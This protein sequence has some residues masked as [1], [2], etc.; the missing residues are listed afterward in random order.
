M[1]EFTRAFAPGG[2]FFFTVVTHRRRPLFHAQ[3]ARALLRTV[4]EDV[5]SR[6]PFDLD[7]IVLLPDHLHCIWTLPPEDADFSTRWRKIKEVFTRAWLDTGAQESRVSAGQRRKG[8]RGVWQ[9]RFWEHA[10]RD[11]SDYEQHMHYIHFNPVKHGHATCPHKWPWSSFARWVREGTYDADW[12]CECNG[13][14]VAAP[15]FDG[16][17]ETALE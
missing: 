15:S 11:E 4:I 10:I 1:P 13:R 12:C 16:L 2:T 5:R 9:Q 17:A 3:Q 14:T 6:R 8:L 7:A